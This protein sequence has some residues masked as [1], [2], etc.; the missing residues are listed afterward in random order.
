VDLP[1]P[2]GPTRATFSFGSMLT[3][4]SESTVAPEFEGEANWRSTISMRPAAG[5]GR[6][7]GRGGDAIVCSCSS[8]SVRRSLAPAASLSV[9]TALAT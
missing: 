7:A 1:D 2:E 9:P 5:V 4:R 6:R 8:N 3:Q